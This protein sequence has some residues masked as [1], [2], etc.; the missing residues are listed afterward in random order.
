MKITLLSLLITLGA[1][2]FSQ[3]MSITVSAQHKTI[4][5]VTDDDNSDKILNLERSTAPSEACLIA[6]LSQEEKQKDWKRIFIIYNKEDSEISRLALIKEN[7]YG[8]LLKDL[9]LQLQNGQ[10]Y[11]LYTIVLPEDPQ[12]AMEVRVARQMVCKIEIN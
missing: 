6:S 12:K 4:S 1:C 7:T 9:F 10:E 2:S 11:S 8:I 5:V 3:Q